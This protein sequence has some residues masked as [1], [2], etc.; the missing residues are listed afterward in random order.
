MNA[1]L[2]REISRAPLLQPKCGVDFCDDCGDCLDCYGNDTGA[3][4]CEDGHNW[5]TFHE[6]QRT[7]GALMEKEQ[8]AA[9]CHEANRTYCAAIGDLSQ[10]PW[11]N[12]P[13]W[14]IDS[15]IKGVEFNQANPDAPASASH[16]SWLAV[17]RADGWKFGAVKNAEAKEHPC[18][19][20]YEELPE[21]QKRKDALFKAIVAALS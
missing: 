3:N 9:V 21:D 17:K 10:L 15:A 20:P 13:Q 1:E 14:Q 12:A 6:K 11:A 16:D 2:K 7:Q 5:S 19:V 4:R 18:F 8:I